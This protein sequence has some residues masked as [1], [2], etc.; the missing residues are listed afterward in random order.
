MRAVR[1]HAYG[2]ST[3]LRLDDVPDPQPG[4]EDVL[5]RVRAAA[6]NH[7]DVDMRNGTS[8]LNLKL[9]HTP[10]IEVAGDVAAIG[11]RVTSVRVGT[12]V[13]PRYLRPCRRCEWCTAGQENACRQVRVLGATE[14]GGY[15]EYVVVPAWTLIHLPDAVSYEAAAAL[16]GSFAP[17][18]HALKGRLDP[19]PGTRILI[20][21]AGS[22][23]GSAAI[24]LAR[25]LGARVVASA[26]SEEKLARAKA[27]GAEATVNYAVEDLTARVR[28]LT[29]GKGIEAVFDCVGGSVFEAS[30]PALAWDGR[31]VTIGAH[32]GERVSLD[33][34][35]LFRNQWSIIGSVNCTTDDI[36]RVF[37]LLKDGKIQPA[38]HRTYRLDEAARAHE[39]LEARRHYGK[40]LLVP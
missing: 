32:G 18:W 27:D 37:D 22:G 28:E 8:R 29:D 40:L 39:D 36:D 15:G 16:Q 35:P 13:M 12:R 7:W 20:N 34:I 33:L 11:D 21:A 31:L 30:L 10:G 24:Q 14:P 17:V 6:I 9:P 1:F 4:P 5:V 3:E 23:A 19:Q 25:Y 38:I 2:P 26:G